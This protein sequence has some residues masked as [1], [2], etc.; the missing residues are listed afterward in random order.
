M[1]EQLHNTTMNNPF[2]AQPREVP[3]EGDQ[4][5]LGTLPARQDNPE[6]SIDPSPELQ[7][8]RQWV[9]RKQL[10]E[11][12]RQLLEIQ[13]RYALGDTQAV[14]A[15]KPGVGVVAPAGLHGSGSSSLPRP[16]DPTTYNKKDRSEYN[17]WE[18]DCEGFFLRTPHSFATEERKVDFGVMYISETMKSLWRAHIDSMEDDCTQIVPTWAMLKQVM[19]NALGTELERRQVAYEQLLKAKQRHGESPTDLLDYLRPIWE[20]LGETLTKK[21]HLQAFIT[22][23]RPDIQ[24]GLLLAPQYR[25]ET[26]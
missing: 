15:Y 21:G 22:A 1:G 3:R 2:P 12:L 7:A 23:L 4:P 17:R 13:A 18:R 14:H 9:R 25:R 26:P 24:R 5:D 10:D 11:E 6:D 16:K 8:A 20:E 19:L